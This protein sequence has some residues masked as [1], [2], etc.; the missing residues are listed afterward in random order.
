M[1][2][3][4]KTK[5]LVLK[6]RAEGVTYRDITEKTGLSSATISRIVKK[7]GMATRS[8]PEP[9]PQEPVPA[10]TASEGDGISDLVPDALPKQ[11]KKPEPWKCGACKHEWPDDGSTPSACPG[12]G[13]RFAGDDWE[14]AACGHAWP[15][16]GGLPEKCPGCGGAF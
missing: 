4:D 16:D 11:A 14:C 6:M 13:A 3:T 9:A 12:C 8:A 2:T 10:G 7:A 5:Q 15:D 1:A